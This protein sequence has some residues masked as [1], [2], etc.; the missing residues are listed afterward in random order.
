[1]KLKCSFK[2]FLHEENAFF[3]HGEVATWEIFIWEV[4]ALE[5]AHFGSCRLR[6]CYLG[7]C[8]WE[9]SFG[10]VPSTL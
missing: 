6:N 2:N 4:A 1:V 5:I 9:N 10:K 7:S 3:L 8:P